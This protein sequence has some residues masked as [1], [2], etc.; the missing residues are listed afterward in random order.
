VYLNATFLLLQ[1]CGMVF[2]GQ[3]HVCHVAF[4]CGFLLHAL[5]QV[6]ATGG[7]AN[8]AQGPH[9]VVGPGCWYDGWP[10]AVRQLHQL[11]LTEACGVQQQQQQQQQQQGDTHNALNGQL[12][13]NVSLQVRRQL[14]GYSNVSSKHCT[15]S[16]RH[17]CG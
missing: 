16:R 9:Q 17:S 5:H 1:T 2:Q 7:S 11:L 15:Q 14:L 12:Q 13:S 3:C 4:D 10:Q 6:G 8:S